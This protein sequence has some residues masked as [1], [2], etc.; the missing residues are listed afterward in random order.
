MSKQ[1]F[2]TGRFPIAGRETDEFVGVNGCPDWRSSGDL[3]LWGEG[4]AQSNDALSVMQEP[5]TV[6]C[7]EK[8]TDVFTKAGELE[9]RQFLI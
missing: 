2:G 9:K 7:P 6:H 5:W 1:R 4:V 8:I 3:S